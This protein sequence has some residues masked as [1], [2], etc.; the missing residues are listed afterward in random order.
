MALGISKVQAEQA[1][2][3]VLKLEPETK[4]LE[5]IIKKALKAI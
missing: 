2:N 4:H 1:I 5:E 3:K